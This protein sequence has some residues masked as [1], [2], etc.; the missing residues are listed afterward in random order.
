MHLTADITNISRTSL[1]DG[2]G[3]R[4]VVYFKG[5]G[6]R[7]KWCHNPETLS[8]KKEI[9]FAPVKCICCGRC[10]EVC[11]DCHT[12]V[13]DKMH[14]LREKC[15]VCGRCTEVCP[16]GALNAASNDMTVDTLMKQILKDKAFFL[17]SGGG[18]TLSG[19][20]CLLQPEFCA[21][22]L[23]RCK[24][25]GIHTMVETALFLPFSNVERILPFCDAFFAD[26][27]IADPE[28]HRRYTGQTNELILENLQKL[29]ELM[30][31]KVTVRI[32]LIPTVN[33]AEDDVAA[34]AEKLRPLAEK[35]AGIEILR[36]NSLAKS[37][38]AHCG[39]EYT[40]FGEPQS[41][42]FLTDFCSRLETALENTVCVF[43][44]I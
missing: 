22:L 9:I 26:F 2:P 10:I 42:E 23:R 14:F 16:S 12:M 19:G 1:H 35:L 24:D 44:V 43:T 38:Y 28:K 18:V 13:D 33:D 15:T 36:Y 39:R 40:H 27:K 20:E 7:C 41:D 6:L 4:T 29:T 11:P 31:G 37:K 17:Q 8:A 25:E 30:P 32:P 5:C 3:V 21:D 34:F